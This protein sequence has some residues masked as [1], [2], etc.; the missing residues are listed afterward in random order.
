M[1]LTPH[2]PFT[3]SPRSIAAVLVLVFAA[4]VGGLLWLGHSVRTA[5]ASNESAIERTQAQVARNLA[6]YRGQDKGHTNPAVCLLRAK[7]ALAVLPT[8]DEQ[9]D[10]LKA[11][12]IK[13]LNLSR[14]LTQVGSRLSWNIVASQAGLYNE[15]FYIEAGPG[16]VPQIKNATSKGVVRV[17][18][19]DIAP[20][21]VDR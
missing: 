5:S 21:P 14:P 8:S 11:E 20:T 19:D 6:K 9:G 10:K 7:A 15:L 12:A 3:V 4:I 18:L 17:Q 13:C 1:I 2:R 16:M